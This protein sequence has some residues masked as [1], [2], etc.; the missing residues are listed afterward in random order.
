MSGL[1]KNFIKTTDEKMK[2]AGQRPGNFTLE[3]FHLT[4]SLL[5]KTFLGLS[6]S[7]FSLE[8]L[9]QQAG[10]LLLVESKSGKEVK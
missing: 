7:D 3:L 9:P 5:H 1:S 4:K 2:Q 8:Q 6:K 10:Y